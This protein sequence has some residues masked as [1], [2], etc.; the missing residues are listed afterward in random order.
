MK[1][2]NTPIPPEIY[3]INGLIYEKRQS[4]SNEQHKWLLSNRDYRQM[5]S[6]YEKALETDSDH[7]RV[8]LSLALLT[9]LHSRQNHAIASMIRFENFNALLD[10]N[11]E[12]EVKWNE[13]LDQIKAMKGKKISK[14][15][16]RQN[17]LQMNNI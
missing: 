2:L 1:R 5:I 16:I 12:L 10:E 3:L 15:L 9:A 11:S 7:V 13:M 6:L 14:T 8:P 17:Y 4:V